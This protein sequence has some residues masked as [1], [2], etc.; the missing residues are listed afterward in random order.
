MRVCVVEI[1]WILNPTGRQAKRPIDTSYE[2]QIDRPSHVGGQ[3]QHFL[4]GFL[5]IRTGQFHLFIL[6]LAVLGLAYRGLAMLV[7]IGRV[8]YIGKDN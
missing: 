8:R 6:I 4:D 1:V 2:Q 7:L 5:Q 3:V